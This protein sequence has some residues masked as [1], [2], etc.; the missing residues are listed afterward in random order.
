M[1]FKRA[2]TI[3]EAASDPTIPGG[4]VTLITWESGDVIGCLGSLYF[5]VYLAR[6]K[7][8]YASK[9]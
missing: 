7:L 5:L 8:E 3:K 4:W 2:G 6:I 9:Q 1:A